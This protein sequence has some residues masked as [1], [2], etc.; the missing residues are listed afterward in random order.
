MSMASS[1]QAPG[2]SANALATICGVAGPTF[3]WALATPA[4]PSAATV[5]APR[6]RALSARPNSF[7]WSIRVLLPTSMPSS[8]TGDADDRD[9]AFPD[10]HTQDP[11]N[12]VE[13]AAEQRVE[14]QGAEQVEHR[15]EQEVDDVDDDP[16]EVT[17]QVRYA[18]EKAGTFQLEVEREVERTQQVGDQV[19][20]RRRRGAGGGDARQT[21]HRDRL[22]RACGAGGGLRGHLDVEVDADERDVGEHQAGVAEGVDVGAADDAVAERERAE[23]GAGVVEGT[24]RVVDPAEAEL[25]QARGELDDDAVVHR[26]DGLDLTRG[27]GDVEVEAEL[28]QLQARLDLSDAQVL[29]Q[30]Q[31]AE[32]EVDEALRQ[33]TDRGVEVHDQLEAQASRGERRA[34]AGQ[35][36]FGRAGDAHERLD[37]REG[38]E[39]EVE[40]ECDRDHVADRQVDVVVELQRA[41]DEVEQRDARDG[42][43]V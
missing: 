30:L 28:G 13:Q 33:L 10:A 23:R 14:G 37:G 38:V 8:L 42:E 22:G 3:P 39:V 16:D 15:V 19:A 36:Q 6:A 31:D 34:F 7:M 9:A 24:L 20:D 21:V 32:D 18:T 12:G 1:A 40:R 17:Q 25:R 43:D 2:D 11:E 27:R 41:D 5:R 35:H 26:V 29:G 4:A